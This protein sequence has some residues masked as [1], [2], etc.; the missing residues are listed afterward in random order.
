MDA[1]KQAGTYLGELA[2][3]AVTHYSIGDSQPM[4]VPYHTTQPL[5]IAVV[6]QDHTRVLHKLSCQRAK[7]IARG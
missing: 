6:G 5:S 3:I 1:P 4:Q 2:S 7:H